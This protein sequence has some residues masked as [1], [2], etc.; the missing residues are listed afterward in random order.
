M[1]RA[2]ATICSSD[3]GMSEL[4]WY[5]LASST[6][7]GLSR[8]SSCRASSA[9]NVQ[10]VSWSKLLHAL[11]GRGKV[12]LRS[13]QMRAAVHWVSAQGTGAETAEQ[14]RELQHT[15]CRPTAG[16]ASSAASTLQSQALQLC[17]AQSRAQV[18]RA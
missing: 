4:L 12:T 11:D 16:S 14:C 18:A 5:Q 15:A 13:S 1:W 8:N 9:K 6:V 7:T 3:R 10:P 2:L 17:E